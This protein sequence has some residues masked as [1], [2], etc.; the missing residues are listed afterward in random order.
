MQAPALKKRG[1]D[2]PF[3]VNPE[4]SFTI[5]ARY[6][7]DA[8]ILAQ[9]KEDIFYRSWWYAGHQSQLTEPSCYLTVDVCGQI[10]VTLCF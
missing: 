10:N 2:E 7:L 9:E 4:R 6:Y 5:P 1:D 3:D 8:D